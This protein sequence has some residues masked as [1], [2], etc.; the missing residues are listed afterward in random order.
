VSQA[1]H[2][3][4]SGLERERLFLDL[5]RLPHRRQ[6]LDLGLGQYPETQER[7]LLRPAAPIPS[8]LR[9]A[10]TTKSFGSRSVSTS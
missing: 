7:S 4:T 6:G 10:Q 2:A 1:R 5:D 8:W 9:H 3:V